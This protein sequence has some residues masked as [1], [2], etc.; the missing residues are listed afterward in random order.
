MQRGRHRIRQFAQP[1]HGSQHGGDIAVRPHA[2]ITAVDAVDV[3]ECRCNSSRAWML[4]IWTSIFGPS[5][6][7]SASISAIEVNE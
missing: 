3:I 7:F 5:K 4:E 6:I 2:A 1:L